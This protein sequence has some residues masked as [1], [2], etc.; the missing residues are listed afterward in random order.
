MK[1]EWCN[2][3]RICSMNQLGGDHWLMACISDPLTRMLMLGWRDLL[4]GMGCMGLNEMNG[5]KAPVLDGFL[6]A[7]FRLA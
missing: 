1:E 4:K 3:I 2:S 7:F 5:D 6:L